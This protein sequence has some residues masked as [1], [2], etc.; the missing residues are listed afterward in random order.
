MRNDFD[1]DVKVRSRA[2]DQLFLGTLDHN[3]IFI[4]KKD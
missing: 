1:M 2:L 3:I 4:S